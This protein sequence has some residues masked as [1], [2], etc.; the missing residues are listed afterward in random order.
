[1]AKITAG[2]QPTEMMG[3]QLAV[4]MAS[5]AAL[6]ATTAATSPAMTY[7]HRCHGLIASLLLSSILVIDKLA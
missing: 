1:V 3:V 6:T 7:H 4:L 2:S 5:A